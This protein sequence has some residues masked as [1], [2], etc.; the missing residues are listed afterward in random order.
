[1]AGGGGGGG[2]VGRIRLNALEGC[3][4]DDGGIVSPQATGSG[5]GC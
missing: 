1:M 4:H 3:E 5:A 2:A